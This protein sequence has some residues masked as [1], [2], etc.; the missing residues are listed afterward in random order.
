MPW[1]WT[2][3]VV[4]LVILLFALISHLIIAWHEVKAANGIRY[5]CCDHCFGEYDSSYPEHELDSHIVPCNE[6][7]D[8]CSGKVVAV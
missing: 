1:F 2:L 4:V 6:H 3:G 5:Q 8:F 7:E